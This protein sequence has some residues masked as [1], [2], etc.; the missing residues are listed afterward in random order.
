MKLHSTR[1]LSS[2]R[3]FPGCLSVPI[4]VLGLWLSSSP[5]RLAAAPAAWRGQSGQV[6]ALDAQIGRYLK[7]QFARHKS[8]RK[9]SV[10][11][12]D[13]VVTLSG[14]VPSYRDYLN[15]NHIARQVQSVSGIVDHLQ[16]AGTVVS[17][18]H[19]RNTIA[20]R[21]TYSR[22]GEGQIFNGLSVQVR[23]GVVTLS[24]QVVDYPSRDTALDIVA[25]TP[26]VRGVVD[27]IEVAPLSDF[28][29]SIRMAAAQA[30][31]GNPNL[32]RYA[33]NPA[34]PIR[35]LVK[36]GHVTLWGVVDSQLDKQLAY[37]AVMG[38]PNVMGVTNDLVVSNGGG[39]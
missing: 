5:A 31:Y 35:I 32:Q 9:V 8:L 4:L 13:R 26:G 29:N 16:V 25:D 27:H 36:N 1:N 30:I 17:D 18:A 3:I 12:S 38:L 19:L 23:N 37:Q 20:Q 22:L 28:D 7:Q 10:A 14:T 39:K 11:V 6:H 24:G 33:I 34:H 21:L 15:A 2:R